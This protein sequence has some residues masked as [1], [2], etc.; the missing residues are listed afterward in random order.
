MKRITL[1]GVALALGLCAA[2]GLS[3]GV[4]ADGGH[5]GIDYVWMIGNIANN[6][7]LDNKK[8]TKKAEQMSFQKIT[9]EDD[10]TKQENLDKAYD[11]ELSMNKPNIINQVEEIKLD[12]GSFKD[13][14]QGLQGLDKRLKNVEAKLKHL[15]DVIE[16]LVNNGVP[17]KQQLEENQEQL[18]KSFG[19]AEE[20]KGG[21]E[22]SGIGEQK[23]ADDQEVQSV[24]SVVKE[25]NNNQ[26]VKQDEPNNQN[27]QNN[28]PP[29]KNVQPPLV[30]LNDQQFVEGM[31]NTVNKSRQVIAD[32][33][34]F[35]KND[36]IDV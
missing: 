7:F 8:D 6:K 19:G 32:F 9:A 10:K 4:Q 28:Q 2:A 34:K 30:N 36:G 35:L 14:C 33:A 12:N 21:E 13:L 29:V 31:K 15:T 16:Q 5:T 11:E 24:K 27:I 3:A 1:K 26:P 20:S 23:S 22:Q 17:T 25:E 18:A